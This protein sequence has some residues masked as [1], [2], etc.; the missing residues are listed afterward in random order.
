MQG[1]G[2]IG[3][4]RLGLCFA[5][6]AE[7]KGF[8]VIGADTDAGLISGINDRSHTSD[9][10][11]VN[12][13]LRTC[14]RLK[15][16]YDVSAVLNPHRHLIFVLVAT[17]S[18]A[19]GGY[20]HSQ[21]DA[22]ASQLERFG[23]R[24][25]TVHLVI[26][27]TTMP[28]Y[29]NR[30]A[31]RLEPLNYT[32][33]Y[34]P[35]FIAQGT[36][37]RDQLSPDQVLIGEGGTAAGDAI[38]AFFRTFCDNVPAFCRMDRTSAEIAKI[39]TNCFLTTKISFANSIGDLAIKAGADPDAILH[40]IGADSRIGNKYLRYGFGFGGPCFPRDNRALGKFGDD[41]GYELLLSKA[42]DEVNRRHLEFQ[43]ERY[44]HVSDETI[45]FDTVT[46]KKDSNILEDSQ[47]LALALRLARAGRKV[48][49]RERPSVLRILESSFPG[50]FI[51]EE[52]VTT[53]TRSTL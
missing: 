24:A 52:S 41:I 29:C 33:S 45:V 17:P 25:D 37:M 4:G 13:A 43:F 22:V 42:T 30:L 40:A 27:C 5:L 26:G 14:T 48:V 32:I 8:D 50:L 11:G 46:Y 53:G 3:V 28:G 23:K 38:E 6:N 19:D 44:A 12:E 20:D 51:L 34:C 15:C 7:A 10:P 47:Q 21:V 9:E 18:A 16:T 35:E 36:I 49:V 39:A 31:E 1:I 2:V